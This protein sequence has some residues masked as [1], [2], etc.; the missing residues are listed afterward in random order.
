MLNFRKKEAM[1]KLIGCCGI[2][3]EKCDARIATVHNDDGLRRRTAEK[4]CMLNGTDIIKPEHINCMGCMSDGPKTVFCTMM[5][6]VR[7][8]CL[9]KGFRTCAKCGMKKECK[10]L[11]V[12]ISTHDD[13]YA[14]IIG[15]Q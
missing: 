2:D 11:S 9:E 8:C 6:E 10:P 15:E 12:F 13:A 7:R 14:R 5:C 4:W 3:C 1:D